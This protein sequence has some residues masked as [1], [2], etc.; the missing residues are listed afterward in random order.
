MLQIDVLSDRYAL[1]NNSMRCGELCHR[2]Q[3]LNQVA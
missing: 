1:I 2:I 3:S